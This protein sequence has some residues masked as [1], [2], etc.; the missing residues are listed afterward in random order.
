MIL[1]I[2]LMVLFIC[3]MLYGY[4]KGA[5]G[6]IAKLVTV[7]LSFAVA[8]LFAETLGEYISK[9]SFG[10]NLQTNITNA[11]SDKLNPS[12]DT[13]NFL[14]I[15]E[16]M[17]NTVEN[18]MIL[19]IC[20]YIFTGMG[21]AVVFVISRIVLWIAQKILESIFEL[22]V[23]KAFNK[24]GGI[25]ASVVLFVIELSIIL[26]IIKV[27]SGLQFMNTVVN[28]INS[29]VITKAIYNHNIIAN[30]ILTRLIK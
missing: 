19:K 27:I 14:K 6:I 21:F 5:V 28:I 1:D 8:Y 7:V 22:P 29:S 24:L 23:L 15:Q 30:L 18:E 17:E 20:H 10:I 16:T 25:I 3:I 9:T 4:K 26:G 13:E 2:I 12:N 11:I